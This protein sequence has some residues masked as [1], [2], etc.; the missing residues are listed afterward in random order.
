LN[1]IEVYI[2]NNK[3]TGLDEP[4]KIQ[5]IYP[6]TIDK[7]LRL[8]GNKRLGIVSRKIMEKVKKA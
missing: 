1:L 2:E 4:S 8:V 5:F 7:E 3:E 6:L